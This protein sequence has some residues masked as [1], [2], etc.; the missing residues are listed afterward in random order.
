MATVKAYKGL[1]ME[2]AVASWYAKN[3]ARDVGR[4]TRMADE[5]A[6]RLP[7]GARI[8][9]VAPGP[10]Y[11][12]IEL[13]RR[14]YEVT[15]LDISRSFIRIARENA[16]RA[17]VRAR[18]ELGDASAMPF[19]DDSFDLVVCSAA[20]KNFSRPVDA[21]NEMHR[22]LA[23]GG[24][25]VIYDLRREATREDID[26]EVRGMALTAANALVTRLI[27]RFVL[28]KRAY[29]RS[30]LE[31]MVEASRFG[32]GEITVQGIG[33]AWRLEK[34]AT[35]AQ[36]PGAATRTGAESVRVGHGSSGCRSALRV[37]REA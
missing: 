23:R 22:V 9:E 1:G 31:R 3:T 8:L 2:G 30:E 17:G 18:F 20:F 14:G 36:H 25:A 24:Q 26:A 27:F 21:L 6:S 4:F 19:G 5:I 12:A 15:G 10:G 35:A 32:R 11:L 13:A 7:S 33:F 29:S 16:A 34:D 28:L 37:N